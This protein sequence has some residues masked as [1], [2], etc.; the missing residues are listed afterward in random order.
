[1]T[2]LGGRAKTLSIT[3]RMGPER[4]GRGEGSPV[5]N[6]AIVLLMRERRWGRE[7]KS[8][9]WSWERRSESWGR[10]VEW[11]KWVAMPW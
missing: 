3:L 9:N 5:L 10:E 2:S 4:T 7:V 6:S 8:L 11:M 1:M